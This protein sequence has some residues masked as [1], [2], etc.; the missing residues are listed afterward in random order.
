[1]RE[2]AT[3]R[4]PH[5]YRG[6]FRINAASPLFSS[7]VLT[8]PAPVAEP[9][10]AT[11]APAAPPRPGPTAATDDGALELREVMNLSATARVGVL[12]DGAATSMRDSAPATSVVE[13][14]W[15]AAGVPSLVL[16]RW[17]PPP[18]A[19][20]GLMTEF[21]KRLQAGEAPASALL[22]GAGVVAVR[23]LK[24]RRR[25]TGPDGCWSAPGD[26]LTG[27]A[28]TAPRRRSGKK[29]R[30]RAIS[31]TFFAARS[32]Q[33][34]QPGVE[35]AADDTLAPH[36]RDDR[37]RRDRRP[38]NRNRS[39]NPPRQPRRAPPSE[40]GHCHVRNNVQSAYPGYTPPPSHRKADCRV[41]MRVMPRVVI[42][43][44]GFGGL[45]AARA[46]RGRRS[47]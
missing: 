35:H 46:L 29:S 8:E 38:Q 44:G 15:L 31:M 11:P 2:R 32:R 12:S 17:S 28:G 6:S 36:R 39:R 25:S 10:P 37:R 43:G 22:R 45:Y 40:L 26:N 41:P 9:A 30:P 1:M 18:P 47:R 24:P 7:I 14:G 27:R 42:V 20:D 5:S 23:R 13:W 4:G 21:H 19:R 34:V 33:R 16:P 3:P